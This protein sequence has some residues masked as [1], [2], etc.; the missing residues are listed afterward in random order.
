M[1]KKNTNH[2]PVKYATIP[3]HVC[4]KCGLIYLKNKKTQQAIK[5]PCRGTEGG[6]ND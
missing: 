6:E 3:Y 2:S 1:S 4:D 5:K